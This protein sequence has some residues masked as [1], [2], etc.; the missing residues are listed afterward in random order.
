[1]PWPAI[2]SLT[3]VAALLFELA[4]IRTF[5]SRF[6]GTV[7]SL[8]VVVAA[9]LAALGIGSYCGGWIARRA[10]ARRA[11]AITTALAAAAIFLTPS[12]AAAVDRATIGMDGVGVRGIEILRAALA[13]VAS[14][15][16][17]AL[18]LGT[19]FPLAAAAAAGSPAAPRGVARLSAANN[20]GAVVGAALAGF[21][22]IE[23]VG[24]RWTTWIAAAV[25]LVAAACALRAADASDDSSDA[26]A[27]ESTAPSTAASERLA[28]FVLGLALL[29]VEV[30]GTRLVVQH[31]AGSS[32]A[33]AA[34]LIAFLVGLAAGNW[35]AAAKSAVRASNALACCAIGIAALALAPWLLDRV[36]HGEPLRGVVPLIVAASILLPATV[37]FGAA[38]GA[39]LGAVDARPARRSGALLFANGAGA[40]AGALLSSFVLIPQLGV[41]FALVAVAG[42]V[43]VTALVVRDRAPRRGWF[44]GA[45]AIATLLLAGLGDLRGLPDD[46]A[47]P[48]LVAHV[49]GPDATV[50]VM[51]SPIDPRPALYVNRVARQGGGSEA[52][53]LE[54]R[55]GLLPAALA[56]NPRTALVLGVGTGATA[57]ALTDAGVASIDAVEIIDGVVDALPLFKGAGVSLTERPGVRVIRADAVD[58]A[59]RAQTRYDLI[60]GDLYFP[61]ADGAG[62]L[63]SLEHFESVRARLAP[64]GI[65]CQWVP[66]H[67]LRFDDFGLL[68][69]TFREAFPDM[70]MFLCDPAAPVPL[71]ALVGAAEPIRIEIEAM[72]ARIA[73]D[74]GRAF[75]EIGFTEPQA[76]L[77]LYLG[78]RYTVDAAFSGKKALGEDGLL[79]RL[80][81]PLLEFRAA[82]TRESEAVLSVNNFDNVA[83]ELGGALTDYVQFPADPDEEKSKAADLALRRRSNATMQFVRGHVWNLRARIDREDPLRQEELESEA[84]VIALGR[85]PSHAEARDAIAAIGLKRLADRRFQQVLALTTAGLRVCPDHAAL[86]KEDGLAHLLLDEPAAALASFERAVAIDPDASDALA[87]AMVVR[88]LVG[89]DAGARAVLEKLA[90]APRARASIA[91]Q[92]V[93]AAL[94]GD[95]AGARALLGPLQEDAAWGGVARQLLER[96]QPA[97]GDKQ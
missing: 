47:F 37:A 23:D 78:D 35:L 12:I 95:P 66:L 32:A 62:A 89:D 72:R 70:L 8:A 55:L 87:N 40:T 42:A 20:G 83:R 49:D 21:V 67:Q 96:L 36:G 11:F 52:R 77:G 86:W 57:E 75:R 84:Y 56:P 93:T 65:F 33:T 44:A 64:Q 2:V 4:I 10:S 68:A 63:Y 26:S 60:V 76:V 94:A 41:K 30:I 91:A 53:R 45:G 82:R 24:L 71:V 38:F 16:P 59:R 22:L 74:R 6:S 7:E 79:N 31:V 92:A 39:L 13:A 69:R 18:L 54:R 15:L 97:T 46:A 88:F 58:F 17:A 28:A 29:S 51:R 61:W 48:I 1:M 5:A 34:V 3:G 19:T 90:V 80:D 43:V 25:A 73:S 27:A 14:V 81:R 85:D 9:F 50:A